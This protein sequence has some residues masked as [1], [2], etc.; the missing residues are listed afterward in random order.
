[1]TALMLQ[2]RIAIAPSVARDRRTSPKGDGKK[3][4]TGRGNQAPHPTS[5]IRSSSLSSV[6]G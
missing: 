5:G 6:I 4:R 3:L 2:R 1:M